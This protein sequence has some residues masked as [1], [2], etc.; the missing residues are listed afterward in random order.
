MYITAVGILV[1]TLGAV[2]VVRSF[3]SSS[4]ADGFLGGNKACDD[5]T[6]IQLA[7]TPEMQPSIDA[8]AKALTAKGGK[9]GNP[10]LQFTISAA[11]SAQV[12]RDVAH[13]SD[14]RPDL[15]IPDS[16]LWVAQADD[17]QT[18]PN[19]A[20]AS[21]ATSPLV[22]V[23][24]RT[25][26]A[27]TSSWLRSLSG[28]SPALLDPLNTSPG[29]LTLLSVQMERQKTSA[30]DTQVSQVIVPLAQRLGSMAKPYTDVN[31]LLGRAD[32]DGSTTV[33]PASEQSFVK[34]QDAHPDAQLKAIQPATGTLAL[35]YPIVVTAKSDTDQA[36][37]AAKALG[38]ELMS[39]ASAQ[40]RDQAGFRDT[41]L[42]ALSGGRGVGD[43]SQLTKP[44][45]EAID[46]TLQ[47]WTR[48]SL[49]THSLAV[50]DVSGSMAEKVG[51]KTRMQLTV[52][53]ATSG[54]DLFPDSAKL[55]LW[56][57]STQIGPDK[58]DYKQ[59]VPIAPLSKVQRAKIVGQLKIQ[60]PIA[61]GGT[62]LYDTA[63]AAVR[64]V[65]QQYDQSAVNTILLFT[66]GKNDD[67]GSPT[68][69]Q[70]VRTLQGLQDPSRPVR[71]IALG[72][73]P[74]ANADELSALAQ[75]TGGQ[76]Y[77]ARNPG[78][79]KGVFIDALQSR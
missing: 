27:D 3:G 54:L 71:I 6:Q 66:D 44:T 52:E 10:C 26:F 18:V 25:N 40:A 39:D 9:D 58:A 75:A 65:R 8:A 56:T 38:S 74:E 78:D 20:V 49:S 62:G 32:Q 53:A 43:V 63:I 48:L 72:M 73:G 61:G 64:Q 51:A 23:G 35:D 28:A 15:W 76:A 70:A 67:P 77:V 42:S 13:G 2:F 21:I 45:S 55:G 22:L 31:A 46:T 5:P 14:T 34:Y 68:L 19:I 37:Q 11:P 47:N 60:Q 29:A 33:V 30:S 69:A 4:G 24:R 50:V 1:L 17:G 7:T 41:A 12:A 57:F 16:S 79:L 59:L 36:D